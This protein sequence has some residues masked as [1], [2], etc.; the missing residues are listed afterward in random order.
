M[1]LKGLFLFKDENLYEVVKMLLGEEIVHVFH[2]YRMNMEAYSLI[3]AWGFQFEVE[4]DKVKNALRV[5]IDSRWQAFK[6]FKRLKQCDDVLG[7]LHEVARAE[8]VHKLAP[9]G[10]YTSGHG[11]SA[12]GLTSYVSKDPETGKTVLESGA[13]ILSDRGIFCIDEF[14]KMSD[15]AHSML[16]EVMEQQTMS[17][18]KVGIIASINARA[19]VLACANPSDRHL[20]RHLV[21]LHYDEPEDQI[22]DALDLPTLTSY[23]TYAR[24]HIH[25]K[26]SNEAAKA[27]ICGY[28]EMRRK[29]NF[30]G[31]SKKVI[32]TTPTQIERLIRISE[33]LTRSQL[34][35]L[36]WISSLREF[37]LV[38][39]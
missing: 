9:R 3:V 35:P 14:D 36:T 39:E 29:G 11:S 38:K 24:Q 30:T 16:H 18:A 13:L 28:V 8:Y 21:A 12:V 15:N 32:T 7:V 10:I 27:L 4:V 5:V 20:A 19:L 34:G 25:P 37:Q 33:T 17:I 2:R 22:L 31:S 26:I 23:I 6:T 1:R